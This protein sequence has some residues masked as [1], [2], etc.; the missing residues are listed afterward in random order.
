MTDAVLDGLRA[1]RAILDA[2]LDSPDAGAKLDALKADIGA[3]FKAVD[4][5]Y[6]EL[7]ALRDEI[8]ALVEK[9]KG[10]RATKAGVAPHLEGAS[11]IKGASPIGSVSPVASSSRVNM[12]TPVNSGSPVN[13]AAS[14]NAALPAS[15]GGGGVNGA[16]RVNAALPV[17]RNAPVNGTAPANGGGPAVHSDHLGASTFIEKG[18]HKIS[19]GEYADADAL[20][21]K[22]LELSPGDPQAEAL[23]GWS[24]MLQDRY[25]DA[26]LSFQRVLVCEPM[27]ALAR[28][29]LGYICLKKRIFGE[30]IEHLSK[31]IRLDNDRKATLYAHFY[32]GLV[33]LEREMFE[34][35]QTFFQKTLILGPNLIE[36]YFELGR[37]YWFNSQ[38]DEATSTWQAGYAAN[39]FNPWSKRCEEAIETVA[40]G[41]VP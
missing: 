23:L 15:R 27:N 22:A 39:K 11:P 9:W 28:V 7:A 38:R 5:E 32:L 20:L 8:L 3:L 18:W 19:A 37:A 33:Y 34:D 35:A 29:N 36:A 25:D 41:G 6:R 26:L 30:A 14:V 2:R 21:A 17:S 13:R 10:V 31:A 16:A 1:R 12:A 24:L 40:A 4:Q